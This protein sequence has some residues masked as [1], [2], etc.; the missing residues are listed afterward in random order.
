MA[1]VQ[2]NGKCELL[3]DGPGNEYEKCARSFFDIRSAQIDVCE[4][5]CDASTPAIRTQDRSR[6][7]S[8]GSMV[9]TALAEVADRE[10]VFFW[11]E[12]R[13][14]TTTVHRRRQ[15]KGHGALNAVRK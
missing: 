9:W 4:S 8:G 3:T 6:G 1:T 2:K 15:P 10:F 14:T 7:A 5:D 12:F 13:G 11:H